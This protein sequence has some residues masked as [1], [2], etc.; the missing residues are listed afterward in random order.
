M[1]YPLG[2][3]LPTRLRLQFSHL[4]EHKSKHGLGNN[5]RC[6][7]VMLKLKTRNTSSCFAI[8]ILFK[9]LSSSIILTNLTL[10]LTQLDTTEQVNF[11]LCSYPL[12][13]SNA[14]SQ[15]IIKF[16]INFL[17][18]SGHFDKPLISFNQ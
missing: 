10:S 17:K 4:N 12:N 7:D 5:V 15:D 16:V 1:Y 3:K 13:K 8:L 6:V 18:K 2:A 14:L 11:L 9:D